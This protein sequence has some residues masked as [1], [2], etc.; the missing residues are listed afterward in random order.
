[1]KASEISYSARQ[2]ALP[3]A[4]TYCHDLFVLPHADPKW[5]THGYLYEWV[6]AKREDNPNGNTGWLWSGCHAPNQSVGIENM[7][8]TTSGMSH[9]RTN[10]LTDRVDGGDVGINESLNSGKTVPSK[11]PWYYDYPTDVPMQF[12]GKADWAFNNKSGPGYRTNSADLKKEL[13]IINGGIIQKL[14]FG[15]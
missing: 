15:I 13:Q 9:Q 10:F 3:N 14:L 6:Q 11:N 7:Y 2:T 8:N 1:M 12:I 4:L 5:N